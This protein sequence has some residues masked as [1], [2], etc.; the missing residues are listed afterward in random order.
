MQP[1]RFARRNSVRGHK[2]KFKANVGAPADSEALP[3]DDDRTGEPQTEAPPWRRAAR[4]LRH[5]AL[6]YVAEVFG[7]APAKPESAEDILERL[8]DSDL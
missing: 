6:S 2:V 8:E 4:C 5:A 7:S 3:S 1:A